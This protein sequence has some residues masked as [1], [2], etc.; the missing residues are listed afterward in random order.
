MLRAAPKD[1]HLV[2]STQV[3]WLITTCNSNSRG[4]EIMWPLWAPAQTHTD[5]HVMKNNNSDSGSIAVSLLP[6][7]CY[8][9]SSMSLAMGKEIPP[10]VL[11]TL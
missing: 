6:V 3:W 10:P 8:R 4:T 2:L 1:P 5:T 9:G 11:T 7:L